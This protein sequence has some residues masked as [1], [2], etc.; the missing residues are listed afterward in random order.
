MA[1]DDGLERG[2]GLEPVD[3]REAVREEDLVG[4]AGL[5]R[6]SAEH[7]RQVEPALPVGRQRE[8]LAR[9]RLAEARDLEVHRGEHAGLD[10]ADPRDLGQPRGHGVGRPLEGG[11]GVGEAVRAVE[12][13]ARQARR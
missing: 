6:P 3:L 8:E 12:L 13:L 2:P 10:L 1:V 7:D 9:D 11:E 4:A 5:D